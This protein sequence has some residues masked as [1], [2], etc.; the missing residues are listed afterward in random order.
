MRKQKVL[1]ALQ[2]IIRCGGAV[3]D[4]I[5]NTIVAQLLYLDAID[6]N[7]DI[8]MY[9]NSPGGLVT[10]GVSEDRIIARLQQPYSKQNI[11]VG[12]TSLPFS[13][14]WACCDV[15][16]FLLSIARLSNG[17]AGHWVF[18]SRSLALLSLFSLAVVKLADFGKKKKLILYFYFL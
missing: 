2:R 9:I 12:K 16:S 11:R 7:K 4:D 17:K 3:E 18:Q 13:L 8:V 10:A 6:P 15:D 1:L 14:A 5:A